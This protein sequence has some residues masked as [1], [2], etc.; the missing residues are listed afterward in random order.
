MSKTELKKHL[1]S[2]TKEQVIEMVLV[3]YDTY[4][5]AKEYFEYYLNPDEKG[6]FGKY[7]SIIIK[8]FYSKSISGIGKM[9]FSVAKKAI[10]DFRSLNPSPELLGDLMITLPE[11]ACEFTSD[12][13][14]MSEQFYASAATNFE[15]ALK[16][17]QKHNLLEHF[18]HRCEDCV[19]Y[20][21]PCGYGFADEIKDLFDEYYE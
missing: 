6:Q 13:G 20:A 12:Y 16:F 9:R 17:L 18:Q 7:K 8:E 14:D 15:M 21:E 19:K 2:L 5:P 1:L 3:L 11:T 4:K 10:A